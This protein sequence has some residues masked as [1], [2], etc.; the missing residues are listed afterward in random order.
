MYELPRR[1]GAA[2]C[3][4]KLTARRNTVTIQL[5]VAA[6]L[7]RGTRSRGGQGMI[8]CRERRA[9]WEEPSRQGLEGQ[10]SLSPSIVDC[11]V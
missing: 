3:S 4:A 11:T 2:Q 8:G 1:D 5:A 10:I 9:F 6:E 7:G